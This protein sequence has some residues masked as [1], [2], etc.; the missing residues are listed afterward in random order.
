MLQVVE[1]AAGTPQPPV[2]AL[3]AVASAGT[4]A[5]TILFPPKGRTVQALVE[6]EEVTMVQALRVVPVETASL[7]FAIPS[8][9]P[10]LSL[11][12]LLTKS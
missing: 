6:V 7:L 2:T 11:L 5:M 8:L 12:P 10:P 1:V 4:V 9:Q 3:V